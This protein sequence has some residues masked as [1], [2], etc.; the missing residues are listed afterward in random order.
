[1][2]ADVL[3]GTKYAVLIAKNDR[4]QFANRKLNPV[5]RIADRVDR[6]CHLPN[7]RPHALFF[8]GSKLI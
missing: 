6:C 5:A 8:K 1:M 7:P 2:H 3:E 4:R